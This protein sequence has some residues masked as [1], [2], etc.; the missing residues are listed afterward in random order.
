[1]TACSK[2]LQAAKNLIQILFN[3]IDKRR[4]RRRPGC[5]GIFGGSL[6]CLGGFKQ[7][8]G[9]NVGR[10]SLQAVT[11]MLKLLPII[12]GIGLLNV[13]RRLTVA[14]QKA[15]KNPFKSGRIDIEG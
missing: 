13:F 3:L 9:P 8:F 2:G 10:A 14:R 4:V 11:Q 12:V 15:E 7:A 5:L 6:K 1:M